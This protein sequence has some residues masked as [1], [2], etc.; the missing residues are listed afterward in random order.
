VLVVVGAVRT[1][2]RLY[3]VVRRL[4]Q[5]QLLRRRQL[6]AADSA[7]EVGRAAVVRDLVTSYQAARININIW[8]FYFI[9]V[10]SADRIL[11]S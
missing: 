6:P 1:L 9:S 8:A 4:V 7:H 3:R 10:L 5:R 11:K 2:E